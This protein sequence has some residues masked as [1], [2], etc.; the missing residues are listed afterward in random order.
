MVALVQESKRIGDDHPLGPKRID[1]DRLLGSKRTD[2]FHQASP[3]D[4]TTEEWTAPSMDSK[5]APS[6]EQ[7]L[8][9]DPMDSGLWAASLVLASAPAWERAWATA[10]TAATRA[11]HSVRHSDWV[12]DSPTVPY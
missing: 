11:S 3:R 6:K 2:A 9:D 4:W 5:T 7:N 1:D 12:T 10:S 8:S